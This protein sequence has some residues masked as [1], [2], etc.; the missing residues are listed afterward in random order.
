MRAINGAIASVLNVPAGFAQQ[1]DAISRQAGELIQTPRRLFDAIDGAL[2]LITAATRRVLG[3][4][5]AD[6]DLDDVGLSV[7]SL[8]LRRGASLFRAIGPLST[9]GEDSVAVPDIDTVE[10][11]EQR[12][13]QRALKRHTRGSGLLNAADAAA[14][15]PLDSAADAL[16][17]RDLLVTALVDLS[18]SEPDLDAP[19]AAALKNAAAA[20]H[21]HLTAVA[22]RLPTVV[23][24]T[25][26]DTLPVE[27]IAWTLYADP[28]R[29]E[30]IALRNPHV[31]HPGFVPGKQAIEVR[32]T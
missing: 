10:R 1:I 21:A 26:A 9:L 22:G 3:P 30:E 13:G 14:D 17:L 25:P 24:Y 15:M 20:A 27:V 11:N 12:D 29:A 18:E 8:S 19:F 28:E 6:L 31:K 4:N 5:G 2:E 32:S 23:Q 16:A 7:S